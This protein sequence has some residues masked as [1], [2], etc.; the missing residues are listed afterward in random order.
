MTDH[1]NTDG[2]LDRCH[3]GARAR[4]VQVKRFIYVWNFVECSECGERTRDF[5]QEYEAVR[6]WNICMR[7]L[8]RKTTP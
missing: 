7:E 3:C 5:L 6:N 1:Y 4:V 8:K 2:L